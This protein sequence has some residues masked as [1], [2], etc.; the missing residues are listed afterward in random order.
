MS[1]AGMPDTA[2]VFAAGLGTRMRPVTDRMP[3]PLVEVGGKALIDHVLDRFAGA[4][5]GSAIV[6]VHYLPDMIVSHLA[7]RR[8]PRV[9]ISDERDL[10]LDQGGGIKKVLPLLGEA[11]F[12]VA[13]TD[14]FCNYYANQESYA[15]V[16]S[17]KVSSGCRRGFEQSNFLWGFI[18]NS[19]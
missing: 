18:H 6:N 16:I 17:N 8:K 14:A 9:V 13:N 7:G 2:M 4:G 5:V 15:I 11:P 10:L 1:H 19:R 12:F 3:K